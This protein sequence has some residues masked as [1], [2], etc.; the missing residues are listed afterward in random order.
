MA[1]FTVENLTFS[2][3]GQTARAIDSL[4]LT[5]PEGAFLV[6]C[7]P[8]GCGKSTLLRQLKPALAPHGTR[9]GR[10]LFRDTPLDQVD[11]RTLAARIGFV[12]QSPENQIVTDK[13]WHELAF[14]LESL[15]VDT[16][17]IRRRVAE[18][19]AFFGIE[20]WFYRDVS[21]LSG[22]QK[23][24]LNLASVMAMQPD[25]LILDEPTSQLDPIA[26]SDF[27]AVLGKINRELGTAVVLTEHRLEEAF[28]LATAVAAA[29][30]RHALRRGPPAKDPGPPD[31]SGHARRHAR[32]GLGGNG[33]PLS[34]HRAGGPGF[35]AEL[36]G[37]ASAGSA[38]PGADVPPAPAG[39]DGAGRVVPV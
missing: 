32:L 30:H 11:Q 28:P 38:A 6:L 19:A 39:A 9:Q 4:S 10:I 21:Q 15:G 3:P 29:V 20:D 5:V 1:L 36:C 25:V 22:G 16:P 33:G 17:T 23:Q 35:S 18:M 13:V 2:Y 34:R 31:V 12:Q 14:G 37:G 8:S 26:A 27:L 24:L 7:G